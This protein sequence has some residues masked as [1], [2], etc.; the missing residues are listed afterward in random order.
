MFVL[1][2]FG[3]QAG[4]LFIT[5][6]Y[7]RVLYR[8]PNFCPSDRLFVNVYVKV[9]HLYRSLIF[10]ASVIHASVKSCTI[11]ALDIPFKHAP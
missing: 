3:A 6:A 5:P 7:S 2:I 11:I 4:L 8:S 1:N 10:S 9:W